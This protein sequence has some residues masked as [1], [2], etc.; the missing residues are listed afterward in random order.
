MYHVETWI[1]SR[2]VNVVSARDKSRAMGELQRAVNKAHSVNGESIARWVNQMA[3]RVLE[4]DAK[5]DRSQHPSTP[6]QC[7]Y[8]YRIVE[9]NDLACV[10]CHG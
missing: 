9:C 3:D 1:A 5:L 10:H 4:P 8:Y 2:L 6:E 7:Q